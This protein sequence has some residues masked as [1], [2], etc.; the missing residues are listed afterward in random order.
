MTT[1]KFGLLGLCLGMAVLAACEETTT[2][3]VT[4]P[5]T[6]IEVN[7]QPEAATLNVPAPNNTLQLSAIVTGTTNQAVT[8][9][10]SNT[11][12][13]T[14]NAT[15]LVTAVAPGIAVIQAVS[16]QRPTARDGSTITVVRRDTTIAAAPSISIKSITTNVG[17]I[18][19]PVNLQNVQGQIDVTLNLDIPTGVAV[20]RVETLV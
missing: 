11:S 18:T 9:S 6:L 7:L 4:P 10:S 17:G 15:G 13:A 5:D 2:P 20:S 12:V 3:P 8:F 1:R 16:T 19:Q 14:V